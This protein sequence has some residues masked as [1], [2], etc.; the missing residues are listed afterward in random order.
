MISEPA[1]RCVDIFE[2]PNSPSSLTMNCLAISLK[3]M[4]TVALGA[5][6][7]EH[8]LEGGFYAGD[9]A[10]VDVALAL[11]FAGGFDVEVNEFLAIDDGDPE[12]F[13]L[14]RIEQHAFHFLLSRALTRKMGP[15]PGLRETSYFRSRI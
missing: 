7:E 11:L 10:L 13:R 3:G 1:F 5:I 9:D 15:V 2:R 14:G 6:V 12:F 8:R 4:E